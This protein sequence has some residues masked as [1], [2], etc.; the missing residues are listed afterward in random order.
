MN[1][2]HQDLI[3]LANEKITIS[4]EGIFDIDALRSYVTGFFS[5]VNNIFHA[6]NL[7]PNHCSNLTTKTAIDLLRK[8]SSYDLEHF[9]IVSPE[10]LDAKMI[11]YLTIVTDSLNKLATV[12]QRMLLPLEQW[13]SLI[14]TDP[15]YVDQPWLRLPTDY[16][17]IEGFKAKLA[18]CF[19]ESVGD[20]VDNKLF[21]DV[22]TNADEFNVCANMLDE[23]ITKVTKL[24]DNRLSLRIDNIAKL[25]AQLKGKKEIADKLSEQPE[26]KMQQVINAILQTA[27]ELELLA[28]IMFQVKVAS[29]A[30][31]QTV[32]KINQQLR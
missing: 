23:L 20:N 17:D 11:N 6:K 25:I 10:Y 12:E 18:T 27:K 14:V 29:Y 30:Y 13:A 15:K 28:V 7:I 16:A 31:A 22:Y 32:E 9:T 2:I 24:L 4:T 19:N 21:I 8:R 3:I 5:K 26:A 1:T